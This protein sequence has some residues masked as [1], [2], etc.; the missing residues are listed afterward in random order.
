MK[1][2]ACWDITQ[3]SLVVSHQRFGGTSCFH[4]Y[5]S[6]SLVYPKD[7]GNIFL[8]N[9]GNISQTTY[10][11]IPADS[12]LRSHCWKYLRS[13][14]LYL[15]YINKYASNFG[16]SIYIYVTRKNARRCSGSYKK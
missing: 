5:G 10:R 12:N 11:Y 7:G 6:L 1:V 8:R 4:F 15:F 16:T 13:H 2:A 3:S 14:K 9:T